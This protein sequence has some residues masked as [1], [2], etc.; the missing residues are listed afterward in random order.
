MSN[1]PH[2]KLDSFPFTVVLWQNIGDTGHPWYS[3]YI[4]K[5]VK[6]KEGKWGP[7]SMKISDRDLLP[8]AA[9][10]TAAFNG[11]KIEDIKQQVVA[12]EPKIT[13]I[14]T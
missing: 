5:L 14:A 10:V 4:E 3:G 11:V 2:L 1:T 13:P 7:V 12:S 9:I 8:L 6:D